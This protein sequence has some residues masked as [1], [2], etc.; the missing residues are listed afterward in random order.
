M[1]SVGQHEA[2]G[3]LA[4]I[5]AVATLA[6]A[7]PVAP[8]PDGV[9]ARRFV[10]DAGDRR[11]S[12]RIRSSRCK[13]GVT[14]EGYYQYNWNRPYDRVNLLRAY[15]TR[16]NVFSIQQTAIVVESPADV[17]AGRRFGA[18][19]DLQFGQATETV[20]GGARQR[21]APRRLSA[22]L[23]GIRDVRVPRR[24]RPA[25]RLRQVR[26]KSRLRDELREGQQ[27]LLARVSLQLPAVLSLGPAS[28]PAGSRQGHGDV[29]AHQRH[30]ADRRL[31]RFQEQPVHRHRQATRCGDL[32]GQLLLRSRAAGRWRTQRARTA[33]SGSS[34]LTPPTPRRRL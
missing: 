32:D 3:A 9:T 13:F 2:A 34:I 28:E 30:P 18:R 5:V 23:A 16:A 17:E 24:P 1:K 22:Y 7:Q 31:Q 8:T 26:V 29:H 14:F 12:H 27:P 21:A 11:R 4:M 20:Q 6:A 25:N 10:D 33:S 15:D 19:V